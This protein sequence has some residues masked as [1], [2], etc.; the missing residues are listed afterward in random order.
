MVGRIVRV[1]VKEGDI[2]RE[3]DSVV[4]ISAMKMVSQVQ[5]A[6]AILLTVS[7]ADYRVGDQSERTIE[8]TYFAG[9]GAAG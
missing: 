1:F 6:N 2:V 8:R 9:C 4:L 7:A 3:G 5:I